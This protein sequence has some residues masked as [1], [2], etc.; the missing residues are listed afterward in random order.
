MDDYFPLQFLPSSPIV[1]AGTSQQER[2]VSE[3]S[4]SAV[5]TQKPH[6]SLDSAQIT[7]H[8]GKSC[9]VCRAKKIK[10]D[11]KAPCSNCSKS[12]RYCL[13]PPSNEI[14][15]TPRRNAHEES[16]HRLTEK[17]KNLEQSLRQLTVGVGPTIT[18][19][20]K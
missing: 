15:R 10:C 16:V 13:Y 7:S 12:K 3:K 1:T 4:W 9:K 20:N 11:K 14:R 19:R 8:Y 18:T 2:T 5:E 6:K 17:V